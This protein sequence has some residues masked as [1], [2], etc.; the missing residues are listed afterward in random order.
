MEIKVYNG[1]VVVVQA[2]QQAS[3]ASN[4]NPI[5]TISAH[6]NGEPVTSLYSTLQ[7][8]TDEDAKTHGFKIAEEW[9]QSRS[10]TT[11]HRTTIGKTLRQS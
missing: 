10:L 3:Y 2:V 4:R 1:F 9:I 5:V 7:F 11:N 6:N 8:L